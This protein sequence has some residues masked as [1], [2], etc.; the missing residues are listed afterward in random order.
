MDMEEAFG[1]TEVA[2]IC[3]ILRTKIYLLCHRSGRI[4]N[5]QDRPWREVG[6]QP[7]EQENSI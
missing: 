2:T 5:L 4:N 3:A 1:W 7:V 6:F